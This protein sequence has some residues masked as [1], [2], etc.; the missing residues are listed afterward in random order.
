MASNKNFFTEEMKKKVIEWIQAK[1]ALKQCECCGANAWFMS[2]QVVS[3]VIYAGS[4]V[5]GG[6]AF[7]QV[8]LVCKNCGNTKY[9][10]VLV[11]N[12]FETKEG[13]KNV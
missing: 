11:M 10:N 3:P 8:M 4:M 2:D 13:E 1:N 5:V 6:T 12:L 9:F 7:P